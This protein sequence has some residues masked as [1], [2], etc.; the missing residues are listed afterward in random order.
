M[1]KHF[2]K[3]LIDAIL[4]VGGPKSVVGDHYLYLHQGGLE[5]SGAV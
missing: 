5:G 2:F 4:S 1:Y 3:R